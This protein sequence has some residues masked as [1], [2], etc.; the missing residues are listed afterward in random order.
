MPKFLSIKFPVYSHNKSI[1]FQSILSEM[2]CQSYFAAAF[3]V[4]GY[5]TGVWYENI[6]KGQG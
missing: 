3:S 2:S 4:M 6:T 5:P 1:L